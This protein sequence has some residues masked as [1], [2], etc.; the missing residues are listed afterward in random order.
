MSKQFLYV[1]AHASK[2]ILCFEVN[3]VTGALSP[4]RIT[5]VPGSELESPHSIPM[6][7]SPDRG[8][9][10][11]VMRMPPYPL[12]VFKIERRTGALVHV[13]SGRLDD[14]VC[15]LSVDANG[16]TLLAASHSGASILN[17][18]IGEDG[19][20][21]ETARQKISPV[22][23]AHSIIVDGDNRFVYGAGLGDNRVLQW[24]LDEGS[25]M[26]VE[27]QP[28]YISPHPGAGPRHLA[29]HPVLARL[30]CLNETDGT[31]DVYGVDRVAGGL[32]HLQTISAMPDGQPSRPNERAADIHVT[33]GGRFLYS[34]ERSHDT[35]AG[36]S[37]D[38]VDGKLRYIASWKTEKEPRGFLIH[39]SGAHLY[40]TGHKSGYLAHYSIARDSGHLE[41]LGRYPAGRGPNWLEI[42]E[43]Y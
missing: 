20:P 29:M 7:L 38:P 40:C 1:S 5:E 16:R 31:I 15:Y 6:A 13:A 39:P 4:P 18:P 23:A 11:A 33:P 22:P 27:N 17:Y 19:I 21:A 36:F 42:V 41:L 32:F 3:G 37:V 12:A 30:Y 10:Y 28:A 26:L 25:G 2:E 35:L 9:L 34:S 8:L 14:S 43:S 24:R